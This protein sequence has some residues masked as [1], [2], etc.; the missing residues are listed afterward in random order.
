M[1]TLSNSFMV[2]P[3]SQPICDRIITYNNRTAVIPGYEGIPQNLLINVVSWV[4]RCSK[5]LYEACSY[6]CFCSQFYASSLGITAK[7][8][9]Q[10]P[11]EASGRRCSFPKC[12]GPRWK[13]ARSTALT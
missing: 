11:E 9:C 8:H 5:T 2:Q 7:S 4:V 1:S 6:F 10:N 12:A 3:P 13:Q